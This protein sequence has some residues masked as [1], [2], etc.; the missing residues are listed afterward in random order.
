[1]AHRGLD[2]SPWN[3]SMSLLALAACG[4]VIP[5]A[6][7]GDDTGSETNPT[8]PTDP[9]DP[10][11]TSSPTE[12]AECTED[13]DCEGYGYS[14][15]NG[16]CE[17]ECIGCCGA[18]VDE[19]DVFRCSPPW[20]YDCY[21]DADCGPGYQCIGNYCVDVPECDALPMFSGEL[22][23]SFSEGAPVTE[24]VYARLGDAVGEQ[25]LA[26]RGDA[27]VL[28][29]GGGGTVVI[30]TEAPITDVVAADIDLDGLGDLVVATGGDA[31]A[32]TVWRG[33]A[34]GLDVAP[35]ASVPIAVSALAFGDWQGDGV[36]D[37][38]ARTDAGVEGLL[39]LGGGALA[40][41][42]VL[43]PGPIDQM[44]LV[45]AD[46]DGR[47]DI[48]ARTG[49]GYAVTL[50]V[51]GQ[52]RELPAPLGPDGGLALHGGDF[53]GDGQGDVVTIRPEYEV[54]TWSGPLLEGFSPS[55]AVHRGRALTSSSADLDVDGRW[56]LLVGRDDS[57]VS[58]LYGAPP[59]GDGL[60]AEPFGC[61]SVVASP[62]V[63]SIVV[64]GD[65]DGSPLRDIAVTDGASVYALRR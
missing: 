32:V 42:V 16:F 45:D 14:C 31:P 60:G 37:V 62:V 61:E 9:T 47:T 44:T 52:G 41:A 58:I 3:L 7:S 57:S 65:H 26:V 18:Q 23:V 50:G 12:P 63:A 39:G 15:I 24:L 46:L 2:V 35:I 28:A 59:V 5:G 30:Q 29:A 6:D 25:L 53:D 4:P 55:A 43:V 19:G 40:E 38:F 56:D 33:V 20:Y 10:T 54:I 22:V 8:D 21:S 17:Y 11:A 36:L 49:I 1:M 27:V 51:D 34:G 13:D 64:V 48:A